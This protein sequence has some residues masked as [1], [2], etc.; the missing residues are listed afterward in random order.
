ML[1]ADV[2]ILGGGCAGLSLAVALS[3][4]MPGCR[5][6]VLEE[7]TQYVRDRTWC[8][9][10]AEPHPFE[11]CV[12]HSWNRWRIRSAGESILRQS[13]RYAYQHI[14]ADRFYEFALQSISASTQQQISLGTHVQSVTPDARGLRIETNRGSLQA[15]W[16][17]DSRPQITL[18]R[19]QTSGLIQRFS[20]WHVLSERPCFDS[21]TVELM[22]FQRSD[23][24]GRTIFFYTL[25]FSPYEALVEATYLDDPTL[26]SAC[27]DDA[28]RVWLEEITSG[29]S[30]QVQFREQGALRMEAR[31]SVDRIPRPSRYMPIGTAGGR[32]KA[33]SG[34]AFLRIQR[35]SLAIAHALANGLTPPQQLEPFRYELLD[36]VFMTALRRHPKAASGY[37]LQLFRN[38]PPD[39]LVRFL[40]ECGSV[41]ETIKVALAL[42]KLPFAA[43]AAASLAGAGR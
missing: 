8:L 7:R 41:A 37:F 10:N 23:V 42:P 25:P 6:H 31:G 38:V 11:S 40:S 33:S 24:P 12:T 35:Q 1:D 4:T 32:V 30:Y 5:V 9:W 14:P 20:G 36:R 21:T 15:D 43:A 22:D 2:A 27:A 3:H 29:C 28:L 13:D 19:Q 34:Y 39:E 16:V 26:A 18:S 17:F